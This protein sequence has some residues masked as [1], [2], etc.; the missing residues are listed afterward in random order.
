M[1]VRAIW[2]SAAAMRRLAFAD[3]SV[4]L[5]IL[6]LRFGIG[7][8]VDGGLVWIVLMRLLIEAASTFSTT[9]SVIGKFRGEACSRFGALA[10]G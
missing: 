9:A 7:F 6:W 1:N 3:S 2:A 10:L 5:A 8:D 4:A